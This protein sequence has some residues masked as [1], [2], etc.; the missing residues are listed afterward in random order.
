MDKQRLI[1]ILNTL[2][3][4]YATAKAS[5][6]RSMQSVLDEAIGEAIDDTCIALL[7]LVEIA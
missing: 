1:D 4:Q 5:F 2:Q 6:D 7:R 3:S